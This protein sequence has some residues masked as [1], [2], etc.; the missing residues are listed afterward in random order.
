MKLRRYC[1]SM[2]YHPLRRFW[3]RQ[4]AIAYR[5]QHPGRAHLYVWSAGMWRTPV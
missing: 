5:A 4:T 1:V 3:R 2:N